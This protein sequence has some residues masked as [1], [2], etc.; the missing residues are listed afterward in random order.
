MSDKTMSLIGLAVIGWTAVVLGAAILSPFSGIALGV[1][2]GS[3]FTALMLYVTMKL[4]ISK[5]GIGQ[6]DLDE[7][8]LHSQNL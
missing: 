1:L 7:D 5:L 4:S 2:L 3:L 6:F 8:E